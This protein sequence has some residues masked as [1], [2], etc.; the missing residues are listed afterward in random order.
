M[1]LARILPLT[2]LTLTSA[3]SAAQPGPL[4]FDRIVLPMAGLEL[5]LEGE[6]DAPG[7][8][9]SGQ[10]ELGDDYFQSLDT[11]DELRGGR[12]ASRTWVNIDA[13]AFESCTEELATLPLTAAWAPV[14][15]DLWGGV[16]TVR[17]GLW[18]GGEDLGR[19]PAIAVCATRGDRQRLLVI[20]AFAD[21]THLNKPGTLARGKT[22]PLL[23]ETWKSFMRGRTQTV[24]PAWSPE[25]EGS[26]SPASRRVK[27]P[28][29]GLALMIPDDGFVWQLAPG[30]IDTFI[31]RAPA[32]PRL[33]IDVM[34]R[35]H[36]GCVQSFYELGASGAQRS[37]AK[38]LPSGWLVGGRANIAGSEAIVACRLVRDGTL[39][40]AVHR[41]PEIADWKELQPMMDALGRAAG[42][43]LAPG[44][45]VEVEWRGSW[46]AA[47]VREARGG[48]YYVDF[49]DKSESWNEWVPR[50]RVRRR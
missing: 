50:A 6:A 32:D 7:Y 24:Q 17:G 33:M 5:E 43:D 15:A 35:P 27:L 3:A 28:Q 14:E 21:K 25:V 23:A 9:V 12:L 47:R 44:T 8:Q 46:L 13:Q 37:S 45:K 19:R 10:W 30:G 20:R 11:I 49:D 16:V 4:G 18:D 26:G 1:R 29:S 42:N 41:S 48:S 39:T 22:S 2:L 34:V 31:R 38:D 36:E 40:M